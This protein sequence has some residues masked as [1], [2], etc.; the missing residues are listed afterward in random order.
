MFGG[1]RIF[2]KNG[3]YQGLTLK[4][5]NPPQKNKFMK[6]YKVKSN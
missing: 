2:R 5:V 6:S 1:L 3:E 4:F